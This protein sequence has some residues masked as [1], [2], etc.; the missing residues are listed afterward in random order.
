MKKIKLLTIV[1]LTS[2]STFS[3]TKIIFDTDFGGD[4][5]DLGALTML[6]HF[7]NTGECELL[8]VM[9]WTTEE[10]T[11][12]AIDAINR[13]YNHPTIPIGVRKAEKYHEKWNYGKSIADKFYHQLNYETAQDATTL[14]RNILANCEDNSV[15]I[16][17][18]GPLANIQNL[19]LSEGDKY[20]P[21]S[22]KE[23][24]SKKVK[25]FSIMGGQFPTGN[26]EWNFDGGMK[27]VSK[28]VIENISV[29]ITFSGF[30]V[31]AAIKS[32]QV[33]ND[34]DKNT[35]LYVG[36]MHFSE[37]APWMKQNFVGKILNNSTFDQT[38]VLYAI[39]GEVGK[40]WTKVEDGVCLP[41]DVG[42]NTWVKKKKSNHSYLLLKEDPE[43][44][45]KHIES[46][47]LHTEKR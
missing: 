24:L 33:F 7:I 21:L 9:S 31:G 44:L 8:A 37:H 46:I 29:P 2:L 12:P 10:Y 20:S 47:M 1:L 35:P 13:F 11:V 39:R 45:A 25:E 38:S 34:I 15:V 27:G 16:I 5:D 14:Y 36:F 32:G 4:A 28:F 40:F 30:E 41:D 42:G 19:I 18:V 22:G 43:K 17:T 3:Q 26:K 23:L 6:H